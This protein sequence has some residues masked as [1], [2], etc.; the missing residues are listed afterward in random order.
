MIELRFAFDYV[1]P[2]SYL[3][4][5][6][7]ERHLP[8]LRGSVDLTW[9]PLELSPPSTAPIDVREPI[10]TEMTEAM[11]EHAK[12]EAIP[13]HAPVRVPETRKAHELALH[14]GEKGCFGTVHRALFEAHFQEGLDIGR[15]D[16]LVEIGA[17]KGLDRSETRTVLG[18][19]RFGPVVSELRSDALAGGIRGVPTIAGPNGAIEGFQGPDSFLDSLETLVEG[20]PSSSD[21]DSDRR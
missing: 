9:I 2:G 19:D 4:F 8:Q 17:L 13:F 6:L 5:A 7:L 3:A 10:W 12:R 1:D 15:I 14:A 21:G 16:I 18:V 20:G 11:G